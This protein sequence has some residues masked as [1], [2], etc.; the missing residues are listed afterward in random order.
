MREAPG[1][2]KRLP[3]LTE[4]VE[5][6][7]HGVPAIPLA[8]PPPD[9][10]P[11]DEFWRHAAS[12]EL[13]DA[14]SDAVARAPN[15]L[16]PEKVGGD[17][18]VHFGATADDDNLT[19]PVA[20]LRAPTPAEVPALPSTEALAEKVL[21]DVQRQIDLMLEYRLREVLTP[22]LTRM[23]DNLVREARNELASTLHDVVTQVVAQELSRR[24]S[25]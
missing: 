8:A 21:A 3:T 14:L 18:G 16:P 11:D 17:S 5:W 9:A 4:V 24:R 19:M 20:A 7:A 25:D 12:T 23:T 2:T 15:R 6:P 13:S 22:L 1:I 10:T